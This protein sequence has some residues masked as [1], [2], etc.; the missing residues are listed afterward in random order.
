M[1]GGRAPGQQQLNFAMCSF[2]QC[3]LLSGGAAGSPAA[4]PARAGGE[5]EDAAAAAEDELIS[6]LSPSLDDEEPPTYFVDLGEEDQAH[7]QRL[8][9]IHVTTIL[10]SKGKLK[11]KLHKSPTKKKKKKTSENAVFGVDLTMLLSD[12]L[13]ERKA[14]T[15][16]DDVPIYFH[17][18]VDFLTES[19]LN[20][21][22]I[23][24]KA[25]SAAR[26]RD[27]QQRID[28]AQGVFDFRA[29]GSRVNDVAALLKQYLRSATRRGRG[30]GSPRSL[31]DPSSRAPVSNR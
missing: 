9:L 13:D 12:D 18:V 24:R 27:L 11:L 10:E 22:G 25:G 16:V 21:E 29:A 26:I 2:H 28:E 3:S 8:N 17:N 19:G 6:F 7:V 20:E 23:F 5:A 15:V 14:S 31:L 30:G 1:F 4:A